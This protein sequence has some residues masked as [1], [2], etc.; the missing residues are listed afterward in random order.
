MYGMK[1]LYGDIYGACQALNSKELAARE[2]YLVH[3]TGKAQ[4]HDKYIWRKAPGYGPTWGGFRVQSDVTHKAFVSLY[5]SLDNPLLATLAQLGITNPLALAWER[6]PA[7]FLADW[8]VPLG[9]YFNLMDAALGYS[10]YSGT[11]SHIT[12]QEELGYYQ[13]VWPELSPPP[14]GYS[15][16]WFGEPFTYSGHRFSR[17][18]LGESPLPSLGSLKN[19]FPKNGVHVANAIALLTTA[20]SRR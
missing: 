7:S 13:A 1:P 11:M 14:E 12:K 5:Y 17:Q 6:L 19:P 10:F 2:T 15:S 16:S 4:L 3:V 20:L 9:P 8:V 18:V